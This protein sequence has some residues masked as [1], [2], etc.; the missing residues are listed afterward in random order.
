MLRKILFLILNPFLALRIFICKIKSVYYTAIYVDDGG[1]KISLGDPYL[2]FKFIK[3]KNSKFILRGTLNIIPHISGTE[4]V[5]ISLAEESLLDIKGDF[6][7]GNGVRIFLEKSAFLQIGGRRFES[8]S[9]ITANSIVMVNK[10][11]TIGE[12]FLCAW[13]VFITDSDW[14]SIA[15]QEH[16]K[17]VKIGNHVWLANNVN[18]LKGSTIGNNCIVAGQS[19]I[20]NKSYPDNVLVAGNPAKIVRENVSWNRDITN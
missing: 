18:I 3:G 20:I 6:V 17:E 1:G 9:G 7:I 5:V 11:I 15:G 12:D 13:Q 16:Q 10:K 8:G 19:K 4:N 14:H 2:K